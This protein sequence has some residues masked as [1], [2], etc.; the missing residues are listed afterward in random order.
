MHCTVDIYLEGIYV[1]DLKTEPSDRHPS[2][3]KRFEDEK[4]PSHPENYQTCINFL[5]LLGNAFQIG[6]I[7][8]IYIYNLFDVET[9][10]FV[11]FCEKLKSQ[12][13]IIANRNF[14]SRN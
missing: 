11:T 10:R 1:D 7:I 12:V 2:L 3:I 4:N 13:K 6:N 8:Y 5:R 9:I 14:F